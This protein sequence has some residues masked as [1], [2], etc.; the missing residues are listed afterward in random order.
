MKDG[1]VVWW[2][3][4]ILAT[5]ALAAGAAQVSRIGSLEDRSLSMESRLVR[6]ETKLDMLLNRG[7]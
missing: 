3:L 1:K 6:I 7:K 5:I 4:G 2:M